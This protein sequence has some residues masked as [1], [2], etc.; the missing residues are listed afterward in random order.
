MTKKTFSRFWCDKDGQ[1]VLFQFPN[2]PLLGWL[3]CYALQHFFHDGTTAREGFTTLANSFLFV[4]AYLE[5][6]SGFSYF[7]RGLGAIILLFLT[8]GF[9]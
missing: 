3:V 1:A 6:V 8:V 7:R 2:A 9:F 4:W 5:I